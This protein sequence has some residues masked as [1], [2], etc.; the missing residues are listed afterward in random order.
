MTVEAKFSVSGLLAK[1]A[2]LKSR[3]SN[4]VGWIDFNKDFLF[5]FGPS[6]RKEKEFP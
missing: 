1:R 4:G 5:L 6:K 2:L 3:V